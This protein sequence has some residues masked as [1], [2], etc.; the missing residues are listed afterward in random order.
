MEKKATMFFVFN[1]LSYNLKN[2]KTVLTKEKHN[3]P[4][5]DEICII[6]VYCKS[7]I[8]LFYSFTIVIL[9]SMYLFYLRK[10]TYVSF[11]IW[12]LF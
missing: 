11:N 1:A 9:N 7:C 4:E 8:L 12:R 2:I 6:H 10:Y 3:R 5:N